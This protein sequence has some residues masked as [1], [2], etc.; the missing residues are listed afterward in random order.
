MQKT[1]NKS[2]GGII[3]G[4][5]VDY[6]M[7]NFNR[8]TL[9]IQGSNAISSMPTFSGE[10]TVEERKDTKLAS[11]SMDNVPTSVF[12]YDTKWKDYITAY[13]GRDSI[14]VRADDIAIFH[15]ASY[16]G[17]RGGGKGNLGKK[18]KKLG[19]Q[20]VPKQMQLSIK[21]LTN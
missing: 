7:R 15:L 1:I 12:S 3:K 9:I 13:V 19:R 20:A 21:M 14:P 2:Q 8:E 4:R 6:L 16:Y 18:G 17:H 11:L 5:T 10:W